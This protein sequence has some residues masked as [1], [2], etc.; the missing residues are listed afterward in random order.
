MTQA[1]RFLAILCLACVAH[2]QTHTD[3][4]YG[5]LPLSFT[6]NQGQFDPA[7]TFLSRGS[8]VF[9]GPDAQRS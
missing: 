5:K 2:A 9:R 1:P 6:P 3:Q 4:S 7:V 8:G